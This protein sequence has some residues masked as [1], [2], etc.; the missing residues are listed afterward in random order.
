ME[1]IPKPNFKKIRPYKKWVLQNFPFIEE[2]FDAIT[3]YQLFCKIVEKLNEV[4]DSMNEYSTIIDEI[5]ETF[6]NIVEEI[7]TIINN[8]F[9]VIEEDLQNQ[10][11][12]FKNEVNTTLNSFNEILNNRLGNQDTKIQ[13]LEDEMSNFI[14]DVR[15]EINTIVN[16]LFTEMIEQGQ[17]QFN[18]TYDSTNESLTFT[19]S[20]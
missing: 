1:N 4:I 17:I 15:Q 18:A 5:I 11:N 20:T 3:M 10:F 2:D 9:E 19:L 6:N 16:N 13:D 14:E 12:E 7:E 8:R